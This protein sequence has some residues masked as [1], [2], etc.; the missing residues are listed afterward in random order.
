MH[1]PTPTSLLLQRILSQ[2]DACVVCALYIWVLGK[3][4]SPSIVIV[5]DGDLLLLEGLQYFADPR[6]L[7]TS[8]PKSNIFGFGRGQY[9]HILHPC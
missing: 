2:S 6:A 4:G 7:L 3:S 8:R 1:A 5:D 9:C